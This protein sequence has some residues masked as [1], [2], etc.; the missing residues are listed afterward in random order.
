[1]TSLDLTGRTAIITGASRGIGLAIAQQLR[2]RRPWCFTARRQEA[3]DEAAAQVMTAPWAR[4]TRGRR[5]CRPAL[6]GPH[7]SYWQR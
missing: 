1:M 6:C 5:G 7:P 3:V 2:C 4:C